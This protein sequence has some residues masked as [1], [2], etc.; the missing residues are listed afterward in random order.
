M[1]V[2]ISEKRSFGDFVL[3]SVYLPFEETDPLDGKCKAINFC[4]TGKRLIF[5]CDANTH[6]IV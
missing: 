5:G 1:A 4:N 6:H 3:V 2:K